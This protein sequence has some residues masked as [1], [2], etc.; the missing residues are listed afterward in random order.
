[1]TLL[2]SLL[3]AWLAASTGAPDDLASSCGD[4]VSLVASRTYSPSVWTD[5]VADPA[6]PL[7]FAVPAALTVTDGNAG[8]KRASLSFS[9]AGGSVVTCDYDGGSPVAHPVDPADVAAGLQYVLDAC[10]DGSVAGELATADHFELH[11]QN[12]DS[13]LPRT[14]VSLTLADATCALPPGPCGDG[15]WGGITWLG[16]TVHVRADGDD[17]GDGSLAAPV[18]SLDRALDLSRALGTSQK[19][20]IAIGPGTFEGGLT[21]DQADDEWTF[22]MGCSAAETV[23]EGPDATRPV[24]DLAVNAPLGVKSLSLQGGGTGLRMRGGAIGLA[25]DIAVVSTG[26]AG[27]RADD[28]ATIA[29]LRDVEVTDPVGDQGCGWGIASNQATM[30]MIGGSV[31]GAQEVGI[32]HV[33]SLAVMLGV[34]VIGTWQNGLGMLGRGV[35]AQDAWTMLIDAHLVDNFDAGVFLK[36]P[37]FGVI[38]TI[39][40]EF[41]SAGLTASGGQTGDGIVIVGGNG[42]QVV[43]VD[44]IVYDSDRAPLVLEDANVFVKQNGGLNN[45]LYSGAVKQ[46]STTAT[47]PQAARITDLSASPIDL[48]RDPLFCP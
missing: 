30:L 48:V 36:D 28:R 10:D 1:M 24:L 41:T 43:L 7:T 29:T 19:K 35:H 5:A 44:N 21:L 38:R 13:S 40:I 26:S 15:G 11:L 25:Q 8:N 4:S 18:A 17:L 9:L 33:D 34:E 39:V 46:G 32:G 47:G 42:T 20:A 14:E 3:L 2:S 37:N 45:G 31:Q 6:T 16:N 12:G 27:I 23:V 22:L